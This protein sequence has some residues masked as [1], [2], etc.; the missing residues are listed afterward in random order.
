M[1]SLINFAL[2]KE[3]L[4]RFSPI[5][6]VFGFGYIV[7]LMSIYNFIDELYP[8]VRVENLLRLLGMN[9][10][11]FI[12]YTL[13]VTLITVVSTFGYLFNSKAV[14]FMY[15]Q[16]F[17]KNQLFFTHV[18]VGLFIMIVPL[19]IMCIA[20]LFPIEIPINTSDRHISLRYPINLFPTG[21]KTG[22]IINTFPQV[23]G[24][25]FRMLLIILFGYSVALMILMVTGNL[26]SFCLLNIWTM[27]LTAI[28]TAYFTW[29]AGYFSFGYTTGPIGMALNDLII[30]PATMGIYFDQHL[31]T[32][33]PL[34]SLELSPS[35]FYLNNIQ[36][37]I[38]LPLIMLGY[39]VLAIISFAIAYFC[40]S[41]KTMEKT[42]KSFVFLP[43]E[44]VFIFLSSSLGGFSLGSSFYQ[45]YSNSNFIYVGFVLGFLF[46]YF[47]AQMLSELSPN[48]TKTKRQFIYYFGAFLSCVIFIAYIF[49]AFNKPI[50]K[51]D[52]IKGVSISTSP[53]LFTRIS[54]FEL[55]HSFVSD[56]QIIADVHSLSE[57]IL[58]NEDY[59]RSYQ[60]LDKIDVHIFFKLNNGSIVPKLYQIPKAFA[61]EHGL[62]LLFLNEEIIVA[63]TRILSIPSENRLGISLH[64]SEFGAR[65]RQEIHI[66]DPN[67]MESLLE[68]FRKDIIFE[69]RVYFSEHIFNTETSVDSI[70]SYRT[71][72][73]T[74]VSS[75]PN[76]HVNLV[77]S[78]IDNSEVR[79]LSHLNYWIISENTLAWLK[80]NRD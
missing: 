56:P 28:S 46:I 61:I 68:A 69:S 11:I 18:A 78:F 6:L 17:K 77:S 52:N 34:N 23:V 35:V 36:R 42:S 80:E 4:K 53:T 76:I 60:G 2:F 57:T 79:T 5:M 54:D 48:I 26:I 13:F 40:N 41:K 22:D 20:L 7:T 45:D 43:V 33:P 75:P 73:T 29:M 51:F 15:S 1:K 25:F 9:N 16:P 72:M 59:L 19:T 12:A 10:E 74:E 32:F 63:N 39:S 62:D 64:I 67:E 70:L 30:N 55:E 66:V 38:N 24:F 27:A 21:L 47:F 50:P 58:D 49:P 3:Q 71:P 65:N 31:L 44:R 37:I 14:I 8:M